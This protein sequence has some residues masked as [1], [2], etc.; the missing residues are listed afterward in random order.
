MRTEQT[1]GGA[2]HKRN[3]AVIG[4]GIAGLS[5]AWLLAPYHRV[6]VYEADGRPGGHSNTLT[7]PAREGPLPVDTGFIVYNEANYPNLTA[8]FDHVGVATQDSDMSFAASLDD[9]DLEYGSNGLNGLIGQ[10]SNIGRPR[11]WSMLRDVLRFYRA[12]PGLL[13]DPAV[14]DL[15]LGDYLDRENYSPAFITDHLL[16]MGAA[17]WS[18]TASQMRAYPLVAFVRFF[19]SHGLIKLVGRPRWRTVTGGSRAYVEKL[20]SA[21]APGLRLNCAARQVLRDDLGVTVIDSQGQSSRFTDVVIAT[22]ADQALGL[23]ASPDAQERALLGAF[24]Y[25]DNTAVLHADPALMP[26]R[27]RVWSSWNYIG[28]SGEGAETPLCVTY[29]M[30]RLQSLPTRRDIFVTLNPHRPVAEDR[31]YASIAYRHPLFDRAALTAQRDLWQLQGRNR[32]WFAGSYFGHGFHEDAL[33]AGLAAA[34]SLGHVRR[35]WALPSAP[36]RISQAPT[37]MAAE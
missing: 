20:T 18:T 13:A 1:I 30:N 2:N 25:T 6:T 16:P 29:W 37:L 5:A 28:A 31:H 24:A 14:A 8:L 34:E 15:T 11:F 22:H 35:P 12:A 36:S 17:I 9:G 27:R 19:A 23:L 7:I 32:T 4:T 10:R 26:R 21:F 33:Q 3:I